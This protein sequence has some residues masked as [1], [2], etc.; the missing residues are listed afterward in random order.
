DRDVSLERLATQTDHYTGADLELVA[1]K[2]ALAA[3]RRDKAAKNLTMADFEAALREVG[4][5]VSPAD[6]REY[7]LLA[8][9]FAPGKTGK[10]TP[11][12]RIG[13]A[14]WSSGSTGS[15]TAP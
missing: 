7:A 6:E 13:F 14:P 2:A 12:R 4:P 11:Q 8:A 5:S 15:S 3:V 10:P 1:V 9:M